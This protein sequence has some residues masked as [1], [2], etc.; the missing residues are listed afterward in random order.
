MPS[1]L[2][3]VGAAVC[4]AAM[5]P[6]CTHITLFSADPG[7]AG[8]LASELA[9]ANGFARQ[10]ISWSSSGDEDEE[11]TTLITFT[12]SG[13]DWTTATHYAYVDNGTHGAGDAYMVGELSAPRTVADGG[14]IEIAISALTM[15]A[16]VVS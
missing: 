15:E 1:N 6:N 4:V 10:A 2:T 5:K 7:A 8:S 12:A 14:S 3:N 9:D 13:G 16:L 11:S